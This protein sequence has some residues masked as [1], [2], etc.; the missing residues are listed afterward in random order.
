[1][2]DD[3]C[4]FPGCSTLKIVAR[5]LCS[6]HYGQ[7][8]KAGQLD[9]Y[10]NRPRQPKGL[11][12]RFERIG[13]TKTSSGCWEWNGSLN[14]HGYGQ[15]SQ[16]PRSADGSSKPLIA[17]RVA[18]ELNHGPI[19]EEMCVCHTCDNPRCVNPGHLFLGTKHK[20]N[21]DMAMKRRS[22]NGERRPQFKLADFQVE[23]MRSLYEAGGIT[24]AELAK[25]FGVSQAA[26]SMIISGQRRPFR[27]YRDV[28]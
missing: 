24:Q 9:A 15:I 27:T 11:K 8:R 26:V 3:T 22:R 19:A 6:T 16:G 23:T 14:S 28:A 1:M 25:Q 5:G 7:V 4:I 13:W 18:W 10:A 12:V 20:N 17:S 2:S 21:S